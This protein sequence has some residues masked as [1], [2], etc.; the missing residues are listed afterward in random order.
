MAI[1]FWNITIALVPRKVYVWQ[2]KE[3]KKKTLRPSIT[4]FPFPLHMVTKMFLT[5][6]CS[7]LTISIGYGLS[8]AST[9]DVITQTRWK[10]NCPFAQTWFRHFWFSHSDESFDTLWVVTISRVVYFL[11]KID[12]KRRK[13]VQT[14]H[15]LQPKISLS[16]VPGFKSATIAIWTSGA[17]ILSAF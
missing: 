7:W 15:V 11:T 6:M 10:R 8:T 2:K 16:Y 17:C 13:M 14:D 4:L 12:R 1:S 5:L 3:K 9:C